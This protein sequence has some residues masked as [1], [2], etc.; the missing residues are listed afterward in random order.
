[1]VFYRQMRVI[2]RF[3]AS[4]PMYPPKYGL[5]MDFVLMSSLAY[6]FPGSHI[7]RATTTVVQ[8]KET[9]LL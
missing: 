6:C 8:V 1:M 3:A 4:F 2:R 7:T 5:H 9:T